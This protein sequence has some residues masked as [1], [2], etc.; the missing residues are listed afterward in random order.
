VKLRHRVPACLFVSSSRSGVCAS[1]AYELRYHYVE[2]EI[3]F[4]DFS[5][6]RRGLDSESDLLN[7]Y[8]SSL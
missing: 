8:S 3:V 5:D 4:R 1:M 7:S 6:Y 2:P